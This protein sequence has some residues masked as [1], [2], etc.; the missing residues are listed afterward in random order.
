MPYHARRPRV[1]QQDHLVPRACRLCRAT[2]LPV[3]PAALPRAGRP[4]GRRRAPDG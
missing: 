3:R 1:E 2:L 4:L